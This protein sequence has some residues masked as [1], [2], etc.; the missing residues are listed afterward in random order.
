MS[1]TEN[2]SQARKKS[3][4]SEVSI[5]NLHFHKWEMKSPERVLVTH[6]G[7][8]A[9]GRAQEAHGCHAHSAHPLPIILP[10]KTEALKVQGHQ[11]LL[12]LLGEI[13]QEWEFPRFKAIWK[14]R[15]TAECKPNSTCAG[16]VSHKWFI[17]KSQHSYLW[18]YRLKELPGIK[19]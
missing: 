1:I 10:F 14:L 2:N 7:Y 11:A 4:E 8:R 15:W 3:S 19:Q 5:S 18:V 6:P 13:S 9:G 12:A 17:Q 16:K